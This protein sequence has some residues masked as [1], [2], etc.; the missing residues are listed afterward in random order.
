MCQNLRD[1]LSKVILK[2]LG[3]VPVNLEEYKGFASGQN[4]ML[5]AAFDHVVIRLRYSG[6]RQLFRVVLESRLCIR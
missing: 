2:S 3:T 1:R 5:E 6:C 4:P